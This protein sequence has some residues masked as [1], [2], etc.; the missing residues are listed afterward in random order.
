MTDTKWMSR[1]ELEAEVERLKRERDES[2][3]LFILSN[4]R[5]ARLTA[6]LVEMRDRLHNW[7]ARLDHEGLDGMGNEIGDV[8]VILNN[9]LKVDDPA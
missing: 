3:M 2:S 4:E 9:G 5:V 8:I 7:P 1:D 6:A